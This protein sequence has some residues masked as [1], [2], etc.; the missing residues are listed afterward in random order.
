MGLKWEQ[1]PETIQ[2]CLE[3][4]LLTNAPTLKLVELSG[5]MKGSVEMGFH[6]TKDGYKDVKESIFSR[7]KD[8]FGDANSIQ[9]DWGRQLA[10]TIY[11]LGEL[12]MNWT[13]DIPEDVGNCVYNGIEWC[14]PL[15]FG[16][17]GVSNILYG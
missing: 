12:G 9:V 13:A 7:L 8:F 16:S 2:Q 17:Q 5:F 15:S 1:L 3:K 14:F 11:S 6:W 10:T 4:S